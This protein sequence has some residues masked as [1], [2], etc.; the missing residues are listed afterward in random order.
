MGKLDI[1]T[2][3]Y[4]KQP[5]IFA[6]V[7]N[8]F[9]YHGRQIILSEK[10]VELD[11]AELAIPYG[12]DQASTPEQR[13][14]DVAK[15]LLAK[16]DGNISYCILAVENEAK[17]NYGM[18]VKNGLYDFL[19]LSRQLTEAAASHRK[20]KQGLQ[21]PSGDEYL[22]GFW[23][24]DRLLPVVTVAVYFG[25]ETWD[26]PRSLKEMYADCGEEIL[27]CAADYRLNLITPRELSDA[28]INEFHSSMREIMCYIKYSK[29][30]ERLRRIVA[31]DSRF[32]NVERRAVEIINA[33]TNSHMKIAE[34][35]ER[36]D[37]CLAIQGM[38]EDS[39]MEGRIEGAI[40]ALITFA[41]EQGTSMEEVKRFLMT[42]YEKNEEE[43]EELVRMYQK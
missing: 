13:Y 3:D 25:A 18:P 22:S 27:R 37:V 36:I 30:K 39:K 32:Q 23:K 24:S 20:G 31:A 8:Q 29:D 34:G 19:Q 2:K 26:G 43:T 1:L 12:A 4:M 41:R 10:L 17:I 42:K 6:D 14:R 21:K 11:T 35:E 9:L 33:A 5:S 38:M 7:F 15:T 28:K 40:E 16:T